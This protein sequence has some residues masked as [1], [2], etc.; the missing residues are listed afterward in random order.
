MNKW[1]RIASGK[2]IPDYQKLT[3]ATNGLRAIGRAIVVTIG[4]WDG[5]HVGHV[6]YLKKAKEKGDVLVVGA[7]S[8]KAI[9]DYKGPTRPIVNQLERMELL[10]HLDCVD[11]VTIVSDV[12]KKGRWRYGLIRAIRPDVFVAVRGSYPKKQLAEIGKFCERVIVLPRQAK[13][14]STSGY[15]ERTLRFHLEEMLNALG[16]GNKDQE[17]KK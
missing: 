4:S 7:D 13:G 11:L 16:G 14:T 1:S 12:D 5:L 8:D 17:Q 2:I 9:R 10:S 15:I 3:E 6:R